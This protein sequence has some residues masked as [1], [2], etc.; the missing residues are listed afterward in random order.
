MAG[1]AARVVQVLE[2]RVDSQAR[3]LKNVREKAGTDEET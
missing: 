2:R 1:E 3:L